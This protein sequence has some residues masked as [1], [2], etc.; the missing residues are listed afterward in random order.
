MKDDKIREGDFKTLYKRWQQLAKI[1]DQVKQ[2]V[3][4]MLQKQA[5][6]QQGQQQQGQTDTTDILKLINYKT[7][8]ESVKEQI[9]QAVGIKRQ[10]GDLSEA[11]HN[12]QIKEQ[13]LML[14]AQ[15][16]NRQGTAADI[17]LAHE[18]STAKNDN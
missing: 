6:E 5:Q 9:E 3:E 8:P 7:A 10:D 15:K 13:N 11:A 12:M 4:E 16:D 17:K 2:Q 14:K 1:Q 18:I